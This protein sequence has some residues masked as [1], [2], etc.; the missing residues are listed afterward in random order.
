MEELPPPSLQFF[1]GADHALTFANKRIKLPGS[2]LNFLKLAPRVVLRPARLRDLPP[3]PA[4]KC[5][6]RAEPTPPG[7]AEPTPTAI[8]PLL[9]AAAAAALPS[10]SC[11][12]CPAATIPS[13]SCRCRAPATDVLTEV[14]E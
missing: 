14:D 8:T 9:P 2:E 12:R 11:R 4:H 1:K 13:T 6:T 3:S 7:C 10:T 5:I